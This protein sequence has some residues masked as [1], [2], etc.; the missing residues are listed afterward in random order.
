METI[1]QQITTQ[2]VQMNTNLNVKLQSTIQQQQYA[3]TQAMNYKQH[4]KSIPQST[5]NHDITGQELSTKSTKAINPDHTEV[6]KQSDSNNVNFIHVDPKIP[7][8]IPAI[9]TKKSTAKYF[10]NLP[11]DS[12]TKQLEELAKGCP[13]PGVFPEDKTILKQSN[14]VQKPGVFSD[15][16]C[17]LIYTKTHQLHLVLQSTTTKEQDEAL[18]VKAGNT[19]SSKGEN[20]PHAPTST[21]PVPSSIH[22]FGEP[23]WSL[24]GIV[25]VATKHEKKDNVLVLK[26]HFTSWF[27]FNGKES[28]IFP[29][30][31]DADE[32][33]EFI[34]SH[35]KLC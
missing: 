6:V 29:S 22:F 18:H 2:M 1:L 14:L 9:M 19:S 20:T 15:K 8:P 23:L 30:A 16:A 17:D 7:P 35:N 33:M 11:L 26:E 3:P 5:I 34:N 32:W 4:Q 31:Q 27:K 25:V 13:K 21:A 24:D 12:S 10:V 28:I